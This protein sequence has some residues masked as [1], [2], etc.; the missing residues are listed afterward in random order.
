MYEFEVRYAVSDQSL[1]LQSLGQIEAEFKTKLVQK[2]YYF[3]PPNVKAN[4]RGSILRIREE[5][6]E[7]GIKRVLLSYKTPNV[8]NKGVETREETEVE[9][10]GDVQTVIRLL[11]KLQATSL[12]SV[13][14][15]RKEYALTYEHANFAIVL[16]RVETLGSFVEIELV[17]PDKQDVDQ[18]IELGEKIAVKLGIDPSKKISLGYHEL[19]MNKK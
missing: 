17:S 1:I 4:E 8:L 15:E 2:D 3:T 11:Q 14:K 6:L 10:L 9:V 18:L 12:V 16:D 19:I 5:T 7:G 13:T